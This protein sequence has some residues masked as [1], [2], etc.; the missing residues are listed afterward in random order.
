MQDRDPEALNFGEVAESPRRLNINAGTVSFIDA[1]ELAQLKA[2]SYMPDNATA[3]D[4]Q[5]DFLHTKAI[6]YHPGLDQIALSVPQMG[7][8]GPLERLGR[9]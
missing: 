7:E 6:D 4:V 1:E 8:A 2:L 5:S 9:A 3:E